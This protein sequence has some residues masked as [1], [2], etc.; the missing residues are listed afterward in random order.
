[1]CGILGLVSR[2]GTVSKVD[3]EQVEA[4]R[5]L[6]RERGPDEYG[7]ERTDHV[8]FAHRR[9]S[10]ID[11]E[12]GHQ[13][14][15]SADRRFLL[16]YNGE[17]Y[18]DDELRR[19]LQQ[20]GVRFETGCDT[21]TVLA[22][23]TVWGPTAF[24]KMRGMFAVGIYDF[25]LNLLTLARDPLGIKPLYFA[26]FGSELIFSS[27][28]PT[29]LSHPDAVILPNLAVVSSYLTTI[30]TTLG[31]ETMFSRVY[32]L[33]PGQ[34]LQAKVSADEISMK[35][36]DYWSEPEPVEPIGESIEQTASEFRS[37]MVDS[38]NRH[39]R[40]DVPRCL[41]LSGGLDS[42]ILTAICRDLGAKDALRTWCAFD[43]EEQGGDREFAQQVS[44]HF[45][46]EHH[47][48]PLDQDRFLEHWASLIYRNGQPLSTPNE[49]AIYAV[50]S[51]IKPYATVALSGEG[52][53]EFFGGYAAPMLTGLEQLRSA[54]AVNVSS[55]DDVQRFRERLIEL[56]GTTDLGSPIEH[57][58]RTNSWIPIGVKR[59][60][61]APSVVDAIESDSA[62][63][64]ELNHQFGVDSES[65]DPMERLLR[66]H[67]RINLTGLL[68]RLDTATMAA[69]VESRTP[70]A[71]VRIAEFASH[72]PFNQ[73]LTLLDDPSTHILHTQIPHRWKTADQL[74]KDQAVI[75][76]RLMRTA[77]ADLVPQE[78][79]DRPKASFPL[80][81]QR[82]MEPVVSEIDTSAVFQEMVNIDVVRLIMANPEKNWPVAWPI[83]NLAMWCHR[84]WG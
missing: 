6:M 42:A 75:T 56:Y 37:L 12:H 29:L 61:L 72:L 31:N 41:F 19:E 70:F 16:I 64:S 15:W 74:I 40:S 65:V 49:A 28:L 81:F 63:V 2:C 13:P 80:P 5:D 34:T 58:L 38:V 26:Q 1:M 33:R 22:A 7:Y 59:E 30:R 76:K 14:I 84:W 82:W 43:P 68:R 18:N 50:A 35:L 57:Y 55:L 36:T 60:V 32:T 3:R 51:D 83:L 4:M 9:L 48:V 73:K 24:E 66:V 39:L 62:L 54:E 20:V 10:V 78:V 69:S 11:L 79:L 23:F 53:D 67:R 27:H 25:K 47:E 52:A 17:L 46:T 8:T 77:F 71:D 45:G 21:E 44:R